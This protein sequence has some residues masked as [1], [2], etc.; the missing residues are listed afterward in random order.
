MAV[1]ETHGLTKRY[2]RVVAVEDLNLEVQEG[3]VFGLL[4]PNGSGKTTT[5]LMLLGLTEPTRGEARVLGLDPMREPLKVK[6]QVGYLPDQ[7]GFYG[8]LTAW[9]NLRYT[10]RLLGLPE[11]E[12][13]ARIEEV[14]KRMG[15]WEVRDRRV[16]AF[17]RGMRQRLGLAEVLLKRPKVAILDEPTLGLD[18][19][20]ARE[21]LELIK[22]LKAEGIT[23]LLSSHLLH[24]VQEVCDRVG[25]FHKGHLALLG[26][27]EELAQ[28]VLGGGYEILVEASPG[29]EEAF[30][31]LEGVARVA[32]EGGRYR[33]LSSRDL[34]PELARIAVEQGELLSLSLRRPSLDEVYAHYFKEVA[35]AA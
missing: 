6:S 22:G 20:A 21:F 4:G 19:E 31:R 17:S 11:A 28:R 13:R 8:E 24:Q 16:S 27:V 23:I 29:L 33:I 9:E 34:R 35:H 12:A 32:A 1:I 2:G 10:T 5:I 3:E 14:L 26:T 25:L 18:P 30:R 15:L 7:V